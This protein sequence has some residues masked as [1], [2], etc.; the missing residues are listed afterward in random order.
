MLPKLEK[1]K[2][3]FRVYFSPTIIEKGIMEQNSDFL[4]TT[5]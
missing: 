5:E 2:L 1:L 4:Y 3:G